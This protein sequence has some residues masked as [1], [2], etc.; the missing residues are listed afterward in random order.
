MAW[1]LQKVPLGRGLA[2][3]VIIW[4]TIV[5]CLGTCNNYAQLAVVRTLL[6]W[7]ESVV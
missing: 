3:C 1:V 6:G 5:L 7:F 4:G 2:V